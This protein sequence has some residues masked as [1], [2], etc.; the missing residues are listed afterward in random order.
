MQMPNLTS[1]MGLVVGWSNTTVKDICF[2][3]L[4]WTQFVGLVNQSN[5][6]ALHAGLFIGALA[7]TVGIFGALYF[8]EWK[9][10]KDWLKYG[11]S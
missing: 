1:D 9:K 4:E 5:E 3:N 6:Q 11:K 10:Q 8:M 7:A 2:T